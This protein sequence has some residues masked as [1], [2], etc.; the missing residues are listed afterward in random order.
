MAKKDD[1][2][3]IDYTQ[4]PKDV[5]NM[6][7]SEKWK[8]EITKTSKISFDKK[9]YLVRIPKEIAETMEI[10]DA[11]AIEFIVRIPSPKSG[12]KKT[13]EMRLVKQ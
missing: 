6:V 8:D 2:F 5:E 9:Q 11:D 3:K 13:V 4:V 1:F 7:S 10:S 12:D